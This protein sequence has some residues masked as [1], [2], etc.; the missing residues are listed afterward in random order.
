MRY[1]TA[2]LFLVGCGGAT[3]PHGGAVDPTVLIRNQTSTDTLFFT[4]RDGQGI[5]GRDN[6]LPGTT[7]CEKFLARADSAYFE[8]H[9]SVGMSSDSYTQPWF[10]PLGRSAW[11]M[12]IPQHGGIFVTDISPIAPC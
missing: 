1:L 10:D 6:V 5:V 9:I 11:T 4:W 3:A 2:C 8:A 12:T 7:G